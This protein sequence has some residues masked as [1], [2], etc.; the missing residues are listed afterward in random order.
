MLMPAR[1]AMSDIRRAAVPF[2]AMTLMAA[3]MARSRASSPLGWR[4]LS[5]GTR[6]AGRAAV[7]P[8]AA[9]VPPSDGAG[10]R[11]GS[12]GPV[13]DV[14]MSSHFPVRRFRCPV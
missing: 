2:S 9:S 6:A 8:P 3:R 1:A 10:S 11:W 5:I 7:P 4:F 12:E 13:S 14:G